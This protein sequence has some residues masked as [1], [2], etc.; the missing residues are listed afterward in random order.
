VID[1]DLLSELQYALM[2]PPDG[3]ASWPGEVWTRDEVLD[4]FNG[5]LREILRETHLVVTRVEIPVLALATSVA[6]PVDWLASALAVWRDTA[7]SV[8]TPMGPVD[9]FEGDLAIPGWETTPGTPLGLVDLDTSTLVARLIPTPIA[10]GTLELLYIALP[11]SMTG[12]GDTLP[13]PDE[14]ASGVKYNSLGWLLRKVGRLQ[15]PE[16]ATYCE[17]RYDLTTMLAEL[18]LKGWA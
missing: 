8:R 7:T 4:G 17:L 14:F 2:E 12:A 5:A 15:D 1:Q 11:A 9:S 18:M 13:I 10:N 3:G 16:R 6:L